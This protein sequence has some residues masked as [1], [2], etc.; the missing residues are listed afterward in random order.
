MISQQA[1][2]RISELRAEIEQ[3]DYQYYVLDA[4]TVPDAEYDRL[5]RELQALEAEHPSLISA[6]SPTQRVGGE[7][8]EGF[9]TVRHRSPM[10][11]LGNAF[12]AEE[13]Q[14]FHER[15]IKGLVVDHV[16]SVAE[17]KLDGVAFSLR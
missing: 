7:P 3:H 5:M 1:E 14:Q 17:A 10:L 9:A 12:S 6:D 13:I 4:P 16:D 11:S 15:V 2:A 8:L